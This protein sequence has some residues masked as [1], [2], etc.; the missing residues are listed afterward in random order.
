MGSCAGASITMARARFIASLSI[1]Q[2]ERRESWK[3]SWVLEASA[4]LL[5]PRLSPSRLSPSARRTFR[6]PIRSLPGAPVRRCVKASVNPVAASTSSRISVSRI[7]VTHLGPATI[8]VDHELI[9]FLRH[10][11]GGPADPELA[12]LDGAAGYPAVVRGIGEAIQALDQTR[13]AL[14]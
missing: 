10:C 13:L 7:L 5:R 1:C 8:E 14:G 9:Y 3:K 4:I 12:I 2:R 6:S 11:G